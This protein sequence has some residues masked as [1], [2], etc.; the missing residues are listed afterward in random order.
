MRDDP[1]DPAADD[2][3]AAGRQASGRAARARAP[4]PAIAPALGGASLFGALRR[5]R[6]PLASSIML[7]P[8]LAAIALHQVTPR[9]TATGTVYYD[10]RGFAARE[11]QSVL[12]VDPTTDAVMASQAEIARGLSVAERI[13]DRLNLDRDPAFNPAL[14]PPSLLVGISDALQRAAIALAALCDRRLAAEWSAPS[15]IAYP[16][17]AAARRDTLLAVQDAITVTT[18]KASRVLEVGFT[19]R[20]PAVAAEGAN[21]AMQFYIAD[22]LDQKVDAVRRASAW[23]DGRVNDLRDAVRQAEDRIATYRAAHGLAQGEHAGLDAERI[24]RLNENL[25]DSRKEL[26]AAQGRLDAANGHPSRAGAGATAQ[27]GIALNVVQARALRDQ[28]AGRLQAISAQAGPNNPEVISLR[29]QLAD[30]DRVVGGETGRVVAAATAELHADESR[31][32]TLEAALHDAKAEQARSDAAQVALNAM[33]RDADAARSLLQSVLER[34]QQ[35]AQQTVIETPDA[36]IVSPALPPAD[37]SFPR[38]GLLL[39]AATA[40]GVAFGALLVHLLELADGTFRSGEDVRARLGLRCLA[41]IPEVG[42]RALGR[43]RLFDYALDKPLSAFA[44]QVR[45]LRAGLW[46][47]RARPRIIAFTAARPSEGKTT[48]TLA[49]ARCAALCGE[50]VVVVDCDMRQPS[51]GR[52]LGMDGGAGLID[53][54]QGRATL[55]D[56]I[57]R[58]DRTGLAVVPAGSLQLEALSLFMSG[59]MAQLLQ[60]LR[61]DYDL[62]LLDAPPA[63]AI[64]DARVIAGMAEA[65]VLCLRWHSTPFGTVRDALGLLEEA[66]ASVVGVALTRVDIRRH[67]RSGYADAE[68]YHPRYGGYFRD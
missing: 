56:V 22:Q 23:L 58:D 7:T 16:A 27:A 21:L 43:K 13:A 6:L 59:T 3:G 29:A 49:L 61:H 39:A 42:R 14:R 35:T 54:L 64:T 52:M 41:L 67:V 17:A 26:A 66:Q 15:D 32:A 11:L 47:D 50:R 1:A 28:I 40:F 62:I 4:D 37:P 46:M 38:R 53:C 44:E 18:L 2:A 8:L 25:V 33:Q 20:D 31:V 12:R 19:A 68:V 45:A 24:T 63:H 57:R 65:T 30:A 60:Q 34:A 9:Y 48:V 51:V 5:R 55:A 10:D 36:R